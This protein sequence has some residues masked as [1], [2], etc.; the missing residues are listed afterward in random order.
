MKKKTKIIRRTRRSSRRGLSRID[1][2]SKHTHGW[3]VRLGYYVTKDGK[4]R[5]RHTRFFADASCGKLKA[6]RLAETYLVGLE[7]D[8]AKHARRKPAAKQAARPRKKA[9]KPAAKAAKKRQARRA[10][11]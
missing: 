9:A 7:K 3:F 8:E 5:A 11:G 2:P 10:R 6:R 4:Y 1:Q